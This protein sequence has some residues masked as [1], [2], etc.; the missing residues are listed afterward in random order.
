[1]VFYGANEADIL[2][3]ETFYDVDL[4]KTYPSYN[5]LELWQ[6][7]TVSNDLRILD[8]SMEL[9][10]PTDLFITGNLIINQDAGLNANDGYGPLIYVGKNWSNFNIG[11]SDH[12]GFD[13]GDYSTVYF[14]GGADQYLTKDGTEEI[15]NHLTIDK[16]SGYFRS[17]DNITCTGNM[18]ILW[19]MVR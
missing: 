6:N 11:F 13:A 1:M 7:V 16:S 9:N 19:R 8:G 3:G 14:N 18:D 15:F 10:L 5:A 12:H 2:T 17:N 4:S